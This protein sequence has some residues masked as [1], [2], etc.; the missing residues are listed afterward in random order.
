MKDTL[1]TILVLAGAAL[2]VGCGPQDKAAPMG[3]QEHGLTSAKTYVLMAGSWTQKR[4]DAVIHADGQVVYSH[5]P[6]GIGIATSPA[7]D[8]LRKVQASGRFVGVAEDRLIRWQPQ[9]QSLPLKKTDVTPQNNSYFH[10]QWNLQAMAAPRAWSA[11]CTGN[12][13]RVAILDGG[14]DSTHPDLIANL[15]SGRSISFVPGQPFDTD[16]GW[17]WHG[18]HVA[19]IVAAQK[20]KTGVIGVAP[21]ATVIGVKVLHDGYG[22]FGWI[23][24]GIIHAATPLADGGAGADIINMSLEASFP[25]SCLDFTPKTRIGAANGCAALV[26]AL[27]KAV[28][29][30][31]S[32]GALVIS[33]VGN[34][35]IDLD[36]QTRRTS[37]PAEVDSGIAI[38]AT[39]P[40]GFAH[41]ATNFRRMASYTNSSASLV[42]VAAPGGDASLNPTWG[43]WYDMVLSTTR[44]GYAF[45][46]GTSIA[47][48]A[49]AGVAALIKQRFRAASPSM[50]KTLL[51]HTADDEGSPGVDAMYGRGFVNA[52]RACIE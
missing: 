17:F 30:A 11:G 52:Y 21:E 6:T 24:R 14:I 43:W 39:G 36:R 19:G 50:M 22:T 29:Y 41:G 18:T 9:T 1:S 3:Q 45:A 25:R 42:H 48:P 20:S 8:F 5:G 33:G 28:D 16:E 26:G 37:Q 35:S 4:T 10:V 2:F 49:A 13:V 15:D 34:E 44:G 27:N 32:K 12:G 38:S 7:P 31:Q 46:A 23:L 40:A 51:A 47:T